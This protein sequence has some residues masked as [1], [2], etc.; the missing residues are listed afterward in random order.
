MRLVHLADL[1]L[2]FRRYSRTNSKGVNCREADV[3]RAFRQALDKIKDIKPDLLLIA[4]DVFHWS[5]PNNLALIQTLGLLQNFIDQ[6]NIETIVI[7]GNHDSVKTK[8]NAC[9]LELFKSIAGIS[10]VSYEAAILINREGSA[11]IACLPHSGLLEADKL[12]LRPDGDF[13]FNILMVHG[14]VDPHFIND[15]GGGDVPSDLLEMD[16]DYVACGHFH[17]YRHIDRFIYYAGA[18]ER[19]SNDIWKEAEEEKG[20]IEFDLET[21][22]VRFH[23]LVTRKTIDLPLVDGQNKTMEEINHLIVDHVRQFDIT[24]AVVRQRIINLARSCQNQLDYKQIRAFQSQALYYELNIKPPQSKTDRFLVS[25]GREG[26]LYS[27]AKEFLQSYP[28]SKDI[29]RETFV[30]KGLAYLQRTT[31]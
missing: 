25:E 26:G 15:D 19:T 18:I 3:F 28:L 30:E 21:K 23:P 1:H 4:G 6:S 14:T 13:K 10:V 24:D 31:G 8:D 2:G 17:S 29:H 9:I 27:D 11:R 22:Q 12:D 16:W 7:A 20:F 5:R